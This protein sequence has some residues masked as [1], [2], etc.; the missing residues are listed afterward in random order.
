MWRPCPDIEILRNAAKSPYYQH[1]YKSDCPK[2]SYLSLFFNFK[3]F[4]PPNKAESSGID[5]SKH[6]IHSIRGSASTKVEALGMSFE[7]IKEHASWI[8]KSTTFEEYYYR[9]RDQHARGRE[10]TRALFDD[11]AETE[12]HLESK[13]I[14]PRLS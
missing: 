1:L 3:A 13:S 8:H 5:T 12:P 7:A 10:M 11:V 14:Q 2:S 9:P 4:Y 6:A